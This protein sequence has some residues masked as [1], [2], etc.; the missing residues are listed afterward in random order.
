MPKNLGVDTF[1][2]P[3]RHFGAPWRPFWILLAVRRC[4]RWASAP[5]AVRLVFS[6][7]NIEKVWHSIL[8]SATNDCVKDDERKRNCMVVTCKVLALI[9]N[10]FPQSC[11]FTTSKKFWWK[12]SSL[13]TG[14]F[15]PDWIKCAEQCSWHPHIWSAAA[16]HTYDQ[17]WCGGT[18]DHIFVI[19]TSSWDTLVIT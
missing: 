3:I 11:I 17:W 9:D 7:I 12:F 18:T 5:F 8:H 1:P 14:W 15:L 16:G 6:Y 4:R 10:Y 13:L 2:D 19:S